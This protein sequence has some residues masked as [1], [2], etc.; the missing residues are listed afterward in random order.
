SQLT[1]GSR[2]A[3]AAAARR[4]DLRLLYVAP[5]RFASNSFLH[6]LGELRVARFVIDEA[7]CVSEWGHDFR[8]DYRRLRASA[9]ACRRSDDNPGRPPIAA[10]TA[11]ATAEVRDDIVDLLG[12]AAPCLIVAGFDRPNISLYVRPGPVSSTSINCFRRFCRCAC[13]C[14]GI[15]RRGTLRAVATPR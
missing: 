9:A 3:V 5:E 2:D 14:G 10:F 1:A 11:T 8:P 15:I 4:G 7:H 12:L 13:F 6:L